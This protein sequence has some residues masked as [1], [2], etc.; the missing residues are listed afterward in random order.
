MNA[1]Y[2]GRKL[3][4]IFKTNKLPT[5]TV[6]L[7]LKSAINEN[8]IRNFHKNK[9]FAQITPRYVKVKNFYYNYEYL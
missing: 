8:E 2:T 9:N 3:F 4:D 5:L 6:D 7:V 1:S